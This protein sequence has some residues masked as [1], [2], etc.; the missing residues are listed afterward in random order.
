VC[1]KIEKHVSKREVISFGIT[2]VSLCTSVAL[3][4]EPIL[5]GL[6]LWDC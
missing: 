5:T 2:Y 1:S 4:I 6:S 3:N